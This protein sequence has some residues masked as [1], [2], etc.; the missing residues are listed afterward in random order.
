MQKTMIV[1]CAYFRNDKLR[2]ID[3]IAEQVCYGLFGEVHSALWISMN[4]GILK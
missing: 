2:Y 1:R 3:S 4:G